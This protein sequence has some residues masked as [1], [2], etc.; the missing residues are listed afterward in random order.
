M[1]SDKKEKL[2][3]KEKIKNMNLVQNY[4]KILPYVRPYMFR[5]I[6]ALI[7]TIPIGSMD[8]VIAWVLKPYMDTVMIEKR[9]QSTSLIPALIILFSLAQ[10]LLNY[11]STYLNTWVGTKITMDL[12]F[13]LFKKLVHN[14]PSFFDHNTSGDIQFRFNTDAEM[15]CSGLL[16][17]LKLFTTRIFSSI[18]LIGVLL[19]NSWQ[20]SIIAI[21]VLFG[22]LYPLTG[23]RRKIKDIMK[24]TVFSGSKI[25]T[26]YNEAFSGNRVITSYNLYEYQTNQ[27]KETL[28]SVFKL[29]MKM[30]KRTGMLTP[31]MHFVISIGIA[32]VIWVGSY[33]IARNQLTPGGFVSFITALL[34]LYHPIKSMGTSFANVQMSFMAMDRV[35]ERLEEIPKIRNK[36]NAPKLEKINSKIQYKDVSFAYVPGRPVLK[37][38]NLTIPKGHTVA[39]VGNSG[40]GKTTFVNL[41][42]RFYDVTGGAIMIDGTDIRDFDLYSLRDKIAVVFQ[43]NVLF[44]GTIRDNILLGKE[45]ATEEEIRQAVK[46]ACLDEFIGT[47]PQGLDTEIGERGILLSGGQ[48]QRIAIARAFIKNAPIVILDEATS[49]LDN[50][51]EQIVQ[52]AIYNLME[53][54]TVFIVAHRLSTVRNADKIVVIDHGDIVETGTHDELVA[55]EDS[56]YASLYKTQLK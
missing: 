20:L 53:D 37:S 55:R 33:L 50:K 40:G 34:M 29:G 28:R 43:D 36:K 18:S 5:A 11:A 8:A 41:L 42:P 35:F 51:S 25:M 24:Q 27:F 38:V 4:R 54:R 21:V 15:A 23:V 17:N 12:K 2:S 30:V 10:S 49:A 39:F 14:D 26:H 6:L 52:Q 13:D 22:A 32:G 44:G 19:W 56:I 48:R 7:I 31:M 9:V 1:A 45:D 3:F 47:L 16:N 46:N